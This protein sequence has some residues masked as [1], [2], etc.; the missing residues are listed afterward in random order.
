MNRKFIQEL[1]KATIFRKLTSAFPLLRKEKLD[2][3]DLETSLKILEREGQLAAL[4]SSNQDPQE[5]ADICLEAFDESVKTMRERLKSGLD[6]T[7]AKIKE[8]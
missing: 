8:V 2:K 4:K 3:K 7:V 5:L 1:V 6:A